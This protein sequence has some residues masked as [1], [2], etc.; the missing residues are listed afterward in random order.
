MISFTKTHGNG[1]DFIIIEDKDN[2]YSDG[3]LANLA[4]KICRR[5]TSL[6][7]DGVL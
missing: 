5:K 1:N 2:N 7:A 6:G 3:E 4:R